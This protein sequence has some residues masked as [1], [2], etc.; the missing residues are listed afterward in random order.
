MYSFFLAYGWFNEVHY[1][2]ILFGAEGTWGWGNFSWL[3]FLNNRKYQFPGN[4]VDFFSF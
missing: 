1:K 3:L 4:W 2:T